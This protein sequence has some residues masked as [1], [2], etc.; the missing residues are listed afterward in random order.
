METR[1]CEKKPLKWSVGCRG[2]I[3][4]AEMDLSGCGAS[5][6]SVWDPANK[7]APAPLDAGEAKHRKHHKQHE[8]HKKEEVRTEK[9]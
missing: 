2:V 4:R 5:N 8:E 1:K 3:W 6:P 7:Y 9:E